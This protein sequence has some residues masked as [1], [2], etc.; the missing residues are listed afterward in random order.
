M[1]VIKVGHDCCGCRTCKAVCKLDAISVVR[2]KYGFEQICVD[3]TKCVECGMCEKVCPALHTPVIEDRKLCGLAYALDGNTRHNGS[4]GGLFGTFAKK[5][6]SQQGC[7]YGAAFDANLQLKTTCA[8]TEEELIPLYKSKYLLC[9]THTAF[10]EIKE[11]LLAGQKVLYC[12]SPCQVAALKLYLGKDYENLLLVDF[13]CHGVGSQTLFDQSVSYVEKKLSGKIKSFIFRYKVK[14]GVSHYYYKMQYEKKGKLLNKEDLYFSFP[15][16]N[17][18]CKQLVCRNSCYACQYATPE[19][20]ADITVGDFHNVERYEPAVDSYAG[21]SMLICNTQR[22]KAFVESVQEQL[23]IKEYPWEVMEK[24]NHFH[25]GD[26][27][28]KE[29]K[30]FME[31]VANDRFEE[32]VDKFLKPSR[33]WMKLLYYKSPLFLRKI[34]KK[35]QR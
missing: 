32:T 24:N 7:V 2:D 30:A 22:G 17:G 6:L 27:A 16:Y 21:V 15:Y 12:A 18:Y 33:D 9:D 28:P 8:E 3:E 35:L 19:R 29:Q 13:I 1:S 34:A 23:H 26:G 11:K 20:V 14:N 10:G 4:S 25:K 5:V 31:S